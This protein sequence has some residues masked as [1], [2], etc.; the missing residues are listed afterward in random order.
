M[1]L[2]PNAGNDSETA[3]I[4]DRQSANIMSEAARSRNHAA[5]PNG[6]THCILDLSEKGGY[7]AGSRDA[8]DWQMP[9][10]L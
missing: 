7:H 10:W 8:S 2:P 9:I 4:K 5:R 3:M 1:V 6:P